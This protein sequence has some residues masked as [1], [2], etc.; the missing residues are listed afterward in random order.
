M[1]FYAS[2]GLVVACAF[3]VLLVGL[4]LIEAWITRD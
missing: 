4:C 2:L 1:N 3:I